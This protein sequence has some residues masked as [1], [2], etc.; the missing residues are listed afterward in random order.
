MRGRRGREA[1]RLRP[2]GSKG[3]VAQVTSIWVESLGRALED[4]LEMLA[5]AVRDCPGDLWE[6][7]M[8]PVA[9]PGTD[10]PFLGPD[11]KPVADPARRLALAERWVQRRSTP[12]S[13]AWHALEVLDYDLTGEFAAWAPPAPFAGHPHWR[14]LPL[15]EAAWTGPDVLGYAAYCRERVRSTLAGMT[16]ERGAMPLPPAHRY[17]GQPHAR[18]MAGLVVHTTEHASQVRQFITGSGKA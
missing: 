13:V 12:W 1:E 15:L 11:W 2:S 14:D 10:Q 5:A 6:T 18:A 9:A 7:P 8:W 16:E 4:A 17:A 3:R